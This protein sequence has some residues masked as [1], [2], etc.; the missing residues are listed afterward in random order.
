MVNSGFCRDALIKQGVNPTKLVVLPLCY[1]PKVKD[2]KPEF[3]RRNSE[4][5]KSGETLR[6]LFLGQVI[7]R[8]GIQYLLEAAQKMEKENVHF[9]VVGP[10]GI[11]AEAVAAAPRNVTLHGRATRDQAAIWYRQADVFVLPTLS[12][13]FAITQ[14]E[15]M[16]HGLP[17]IT[18]PCCGEVV[19]DGVDGLVVPPRDPDA[20]VK[21]FQRYLSE[22]EL[23]HAQRKAALSKAGQ[24][25]LE[26]LVE[27]LGHL[28]AA[29]SKS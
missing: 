15:A 1:E 16:S 11:S 18:T 23:L 25:T 26:H 4:D 6:V 2:L 19:S 17:V 10:I 13:G 20:L 14:L 21:A 7:M 28:E 27:N 9:D 8:K 22:P 29:L 3:E 5:R 12:D 24:F